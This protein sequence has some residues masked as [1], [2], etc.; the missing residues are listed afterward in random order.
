MRGH[1][2]PMWK[3]MWPTEKQWY[4]AIANETQ[5]GQVRPSKTNCE[6]TPYSAPSPQPRIQLQ[7]ASSHYT[8]DGIN[9]ATLWCSEALLLIR[10]RK[11]FLPRNSSRKMIS[12][13]YSVY[14]AP[15]GDAHFF[16]FRREFRVCEDLVIVRIY[17]FLLVQ[18]ELS[19]DKF[20]WWTTSQ[21]NRCYYKWFLMY[22][23]VKAGTKP[24][25]GFNWHLFNIFVRFLYILPSRCCLI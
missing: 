19:Q 17:S 22:P 16:S 14:P 6:L 21:S 9:S 8:V 23:H 18:N 4:Q 15:N 1:V 11:R 5:W 12:G 25:A 13:W 20:R 7:L 24:N 10:R 2:T 3:Q